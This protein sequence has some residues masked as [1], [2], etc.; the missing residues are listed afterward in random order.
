MKP[1]V[2][3][4]L[5]FKTRFHISRS[6]YR[7]LKSLWQPI[8]IVFRSYIILQPWILLVLLFVVKLLWDKWNIFIVKFITISTLLGKAIYVKKPYFEKSS[9]LTHVKKKNPNCM[10]IISIKPCIKIV[11]FITLGSGVQTLRRCQYSHKVKMFF[12][13]FLYIWDKHSA[14]F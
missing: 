5:R 8:A 3:P 12:S 6:L 1:V 4:M 2:S 14:W 10:I 7:S 9:S 13:T 11:K